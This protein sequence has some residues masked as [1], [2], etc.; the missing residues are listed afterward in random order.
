MLAR[1]RL[2]AVKLE[3][4]T[5]RPLVPDDLLCL[6][7]K[8]TTPNVQRMRDPHHRLARLLATGLRPKDAAEQTGYSIARVYVLH[9]DP[10]FM[11]L[12]AKYSADVHEAYVS[13][14]EERYRLANEVNVKALRTIAE[15]FD[16]ADEEC[17][18][19]PLNRALAIFSDTADRT[20]LVKKSTVTNINVDFAKNL[21]RAR[22]VRDAQRA[23]VIDGDAT[24][25]KLVRRI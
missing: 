9:S 1:G 15:H 22:Q 16:K 13:G 6:R 3:I 19:I 2:P 4:G 12:I 8:R 14:E 18:L 10:S 20:G 7:Q 25:T 23:Q 5:I 11:D 17:E 24:E 21:E